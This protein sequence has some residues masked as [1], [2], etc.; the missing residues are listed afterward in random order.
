MYFMQRRNIDQV[1][2]KNIIIYKKRKYKS[3]INLVFAIK[4]L[5]DSVI[6][7][8]TVDKH[9]YDSNHLLIIST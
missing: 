3:T 1:L 5:V 2:P 9:D 6:S 8:N 7:Y 4:L